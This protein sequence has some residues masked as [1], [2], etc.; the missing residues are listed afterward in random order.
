MGPERDSSATWVRAAAPAWLPRRR[1]RGPRPL[2]AMRA[3]PA[4]RAAAADCWRALWI[5]RALLWPTAIIALVVFGRARTSALDPSGLTH[6]LGVWGD[7][8]LS[9]AARWDAAWLLSIARD[10]YGTLGSASA[11]ARA[12][13]FPLYPLLVR[14][15]GEL[16]LPLVLGGLVISLGAFAAALY[17]LH[18]L[19][20]L[21]QAFRRRAPETA[22]RTAVYL[23][24]FFPTAVFFSAVYTESL[25]LALSVGVFWAA[26]HG[27]WAVVGGLGALAAAT[28]NTGVLLLIPAALLYLYG[29]RTDRHPDAP[30]RGWRPR[31]R[32]R[33]DALWLALMPA[34]LLAYGAYWG[35]RGAS[36][37]L[38][39]HAQGAWHRHFAPLSGIGRGVAAGL[40]GIRQLLVMPA[41]HAYFSAW[42]GDPV[43]A[44]RH[45][46]VDL[47][48]LIALVAAV[49]GIARALPIA[50]GA[51]TLALL[52]AAL[53][54]PVT[55]EPLMSLARFAAV[56]FPIYVW[57]GAALAG[58][59]RLRIALLV[60][61]ALVMV[62][63]GTQ[64]AT[65][66][67]VA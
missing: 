67:W 39:L 2:A 65:W 25:Y 49:Y 53:C 32:L 62:G 16:G 42:H 17:G 4:S 43:V 44:A 48:V 1:P 7:R 9:P 24:A 35:L 36:V 64:L 38:P 26:R 5:S 28:R 63:L 55:S 54:E 31:Y 46:V 40:D 19:T 50:Y 33:R 15:L 47:I 6:G 30:D 61:S 11:S 57:G 66:H 52:A 13:F 3:D 21:E 20:A 45:S 10:G 41:H 60:G 37:L 59:A 29:P 27:R 12:A 22:A 18:R 8:L 56:L 23:A 34:G 51:Y 58:R 14:A